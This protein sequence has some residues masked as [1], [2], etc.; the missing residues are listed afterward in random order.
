M[1]LIRPARPHQLIVV[2]FVLLVIQLPGCDTGEPEKKDS[3]TAISGD[4]SSLDQASSGMSETSLRESL[5][6]V[7]STARAGRFDQAE[8]L[9]RNVLVRYPDDAEALQLAGDIAVALQ[10]PTVA[11]DRYVAANEQLDEPSIDVLDKIGR[12]W[13]QLGQPFQAIDALKQMVDIDPNSATTRRDLAGLQ[14]SMGLEREAAK[15]L[16]FLVQRNQAGVDELLILSDLSRPQTDDAICNYAI[17]HHPDDQRPRYALARKACYDNRWSEVVGDLQAVWEQHPEFAPASAYYARALIESSIKDNGSQQRIRAWLPTVTAE[18]RQQPQ[19]WIAAGRWSEHQKQAEQAAHAYWNAVRIDENNGEALSRLAGSLSQIG[20]ADEARK[21]AQRA[22][23][24]TAMRDDIDSLL[25][26]RRH[27]QRAATKI[28]KSMQKLGRLWEAAHWARLAVLMT[29]D[30]DDQ[31]KTV[32]TEI[33][34]TLNTQTPWQLPERL[35]ASAVDV[36]SL[37]SPDWDIRRTAS[38]PS[39]Q[40]ALAVIRFEDEA[41]QRKLDHVCQ[42]AAAANGE[43]G[44]WIY[45]SGAGGAGVIDYDLDGWSDL[46]FTNS[47]GQPLQNDSSSNRLYRNLDGEFSET[48]GP[49]NCIDQCYA[50]GIAVGDVNS[51]GFSDL[52]LGAFGDN[53]LLINQGD[54]TFRDV[55]TNWNVAGNGEWTTSVGIADLNIDGLADLFAVQ[56]VSGDDVVTRKCFPDELKEHRSCGPLVFPAQF[57]RVFAGKASGGF[58]DR[59]DQ[60]LS[61]TEPGRGLG[62]V[63]GQLDGV[64]GVDVYVANDM[65]ANHFWSAASSETSST[66]ETNQP[67]LFQLTEQ[68]AARGLAFNARS[69]SQASMGIAA[70]DADG[71]GDIDFYVTHF[72]DDYNTAYMQVHSGVWS[73]QTESLGL[74]EPTMQTLGYGTQWIDADCD[75][76][77]ELVVANG[78]VDDFTHSG[79]S[80]R[81]PMQLFRRSGDDRFRMVAADQAGNAFAEKRLGRALLTV[82]VNR[83]RKLDLVAANLFEPVSLLVNHSEQVYPTIE[84]ELIGTRCHRDAVGAVVTLRQ[85]GMSVTK[86]RVAGDGYQ[87]SNESRLRFVCGVPDAKSGKGAWAAT[88]KWP[89]GQTEEYSG[90][91]PGG[92]YVCVQ[93][94]G[95]MFSRE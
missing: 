81:M 55:T 38:D 90:L 29:Q 31:A 26:W 59:T 50:Q 89:D 70:D 53:R 69:L 54:G 82:D 8:E 10:Q 92:S 11:I 93:G 12:Q 32:F 76:Q 16:R 63:I 44:L 21:V 91:M 40:N 68:A 80:Y 94:D 41:S 34:K 49:A 95:V 36:S 22:A 15:H 25:Y 14:A 43:S 9:I 17:E 57:D 35:V 27:S 33:R 62:L 79:Q 6:Q 20:K 61:E 87:C 52:Y 28:A 78:H 83:D 73:D 30:Q 72:S 51:D 2:I 85:D 1:Q 13:M 23:L 65:T 58:S 60:W 88:V 86:F 64:A 48:T 75:G 45:Q 3:I 42:I 18:V 67:E 4:E 66:L 46:Y 77:S 56:Y 24:V 71:D 5:Q 84:L 19:Y 74:A 47:D 39:E 7:T 37:P